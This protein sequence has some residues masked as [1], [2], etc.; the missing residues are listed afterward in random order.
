MSI[1]ESLKKTI[2]DIDL[3]RRVEELNQLAQKAVADVK[4]QLGTLAGDNRGKV[5]EWVAK[6]T[7]SLDA[8]T[9]GKYHDKIQKFSVVVGQTVDKVAAQRPAG[10]ASAD[11]A[12]DDAATPTAFEPEYM[13]SDDPW[14]DA[15]MRDATPA[16]TLA[17]VTVT[18]AEAAVDGA[19]EPGADHTG[20]PQ[21]R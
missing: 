18:D 6:A 5:D 8:K 10:D 19:D 2:D 21:E 9:D 20:W 15:T 13:P 17:D 11:R 4:A 14:S 7:E 16:D 1:N 12:G 3:D